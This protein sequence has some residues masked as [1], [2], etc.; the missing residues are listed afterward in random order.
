VPADLLSAASQLPPQLALPDDPAATAAAV[1]AEWEQQLQPVMSQLAALLEVHW[2]QPE[3][4]AAGALELARA[5]ATRSCA[6]LR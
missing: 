4:Q 6:H 1:Q 3:Q 2:Q 5:A